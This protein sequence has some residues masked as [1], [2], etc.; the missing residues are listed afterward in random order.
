MIN[1]IYNWGTMYFEVKSHLGV[2]KPRLSK[3][4]QGMYGFVQS[5]LKR[6]VSKKGHWKNVSD[7]TFNNNNNNNN[8]IASK[9]RKF[10]VQFEA[11]SSLSFSLT[12]LILFAS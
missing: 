11:E 4:Q 6:A 5:R 2:A 3:A 7:E 12:T 8:K 10:S 1:N 9:K